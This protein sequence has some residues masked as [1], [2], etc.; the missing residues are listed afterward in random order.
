MRSGKRETV[1]I[2]ALA[3]TAR[4]TAAMGSEE[5]HLNVLLIVR[6]KF[7]RECPQ[8]IIFEDGGEPRR[9]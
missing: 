8:I 4:M 7:S 3:V 9:N 5:S 1:P 2:A 6:N